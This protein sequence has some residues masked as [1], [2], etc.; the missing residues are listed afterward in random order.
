[1]EPLPAGSMYRHAEPSITA[2]EVG[3][4]YIRKRFAKCV[5]G[6]RASQIDAYLVSQN[7]EEGW[8]KLAEVRNGKMTSSDSVLTKC[9]GREAGLDDMTTRMNIPSFRLMMAE[10]AYLARFESAPQT[11]AD[12]PEVLTRAPLTVGVDPRASVFLAAVADCLVYRDLRGADALVRTKSDTPEE[13]T[14][15]VSL[16]PAVGDCLPKDRTLKLN[17]TIIRSLAV[18]GLWARYART[19]H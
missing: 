10:E 11:P 19:V 4:A 7:Y 18:E 3:T 9:L 13:R 17:A 15:A 1:M 2:R 16:A 8:M 6:Y 14:A 5:Y 12:A